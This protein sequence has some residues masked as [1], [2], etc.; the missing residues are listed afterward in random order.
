VVL[1]LPKRALILALALCGVVLVYLL[2]SDPQQQTTPE[3]ASCQLTVL[4]D[5]LNVRSAPSMDSS[6]VDRVEYASTLDARPTVTNGFRMLDE[7]RWAAE[8]F[9]DPLDAA[10]CEQD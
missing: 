1:G 3:A 9:L 4:A 5:V 7:G 10:A 6:V 2:G 8:E